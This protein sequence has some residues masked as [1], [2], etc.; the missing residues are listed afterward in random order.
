LIKTSFKLLL[1]ISH[2]LLVQAL[3]KGR[4]NQKHKQVYLS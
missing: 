1:I 4:Q 2:F 3:Q